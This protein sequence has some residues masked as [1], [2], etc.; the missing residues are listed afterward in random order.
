MNVRCLLLLA[1]TAVTA[2]AEQQGPPLVA[3]N[4][5][6][7]APAPGMPMAAGYL[8]LENRSGAAIRITHVTSP[9]FEAVEF[10]ETTVEDGIARMREIGAFEIAPGESVTFERGGKHLMLMRPIGAPREVTLNLY[11]DDL[12]L[13]SVTTEFRAATPSNRGTD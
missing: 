5:V 1:I 4:V 10:H 9:E 7:T 6:V 3:E 2:C 12:L 11:S 13:I 8:D